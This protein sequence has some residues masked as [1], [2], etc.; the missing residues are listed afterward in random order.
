M[1]AWESEQY[2]EREKR[3]DLNLIADTVL[4]Q[5]ARIFLEKQNQKEMFTYS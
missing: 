5:H 3:L 2:F 1:D 4:V